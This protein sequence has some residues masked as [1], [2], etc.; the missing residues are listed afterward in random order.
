M[1][2]KIFK[3]LIKREENNKYAI[4]RIS[5]IQAVLDSTMGKAIRGVLG[6]REGMMFSVECTKDQYNTFADLVEDM[7]PGLCVFNC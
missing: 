2:K 3:T 7:Y 5:G 6:R 4:G 1:D